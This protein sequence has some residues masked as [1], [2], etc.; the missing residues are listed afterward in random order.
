LP[1]LL[2]GLTA[3]GALVLGLG[4]TTGLLQLDSFGGYSPL[5]VHVELGLLL[6]PL[7]GW[8]LSKRWERRPSLPA[9]L[10]RRRTLAHLGVLGI[11]ALGG[12]RLVDAM[13]GAMAARGERRAS[14]SRHIGSFT[15]NA[16]TE[17]IWQFD[18][19]PPIEPE[20]WRLQ[21]ADQRGSSVT[22]T[23]AALQDLPPATFDAL[24]D[25]TGGWWTEQRWSGWRV[26]DVLRLAG[27]DDRT[28]TDG[29][30]EVVSMTGHRWTFPLPEF[31]T[32]LLAT[33]VGGK[34]ISPGHGAPVR[35]VA[36][37][38]RG[39]QWVKWV[40]RIGIL[41]SVESLV[42]VEPRAGGVIG[43]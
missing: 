28:T 26:D 24:L 20:E 35:L 8:H 2:T 25:C 30:V 19:V 4:W 9:L 37:N 15:G 40:D 10:A 13:T 22:L 41:P 39:F 33:H 32:M 11:G 1:G 17:E 6:L 18:A 12:W 21:V 3:L 27:L 42:G 36:P 16:F 29:L 31:R 34:P 5:N 7:L 43:G 23:L 38:R 14:G